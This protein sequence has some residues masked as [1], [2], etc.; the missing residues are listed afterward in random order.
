MELG[1]YFRNKRMK[2]NT[3]L[4]LVNGHYELYVNDRFFC[5]GDTP[6]ECYEELEKN[7]EENEH[8]GMLRFY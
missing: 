4:I 3:K 2:Y 6:K 8:R 5:S 7:E 1:G